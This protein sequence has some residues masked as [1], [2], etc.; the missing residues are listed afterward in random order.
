MLFTTTL[1]HTLNAGVFY[2]FGGR[3]NDGNGAG[4]DQMVGLSDVWA[5]TAS[6]NRWALLSQASQAGTQ[7]AP[8]NRQHAAM[9]HAA[10]KLL[11]FG[12]VDPRSQVRLISCCGYSYTPTQKHTRTHTHTRTHA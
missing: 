7:A 2:I 11:L 8:S 9:A 12:G 6:A 4:A 10:G 5:Y 3:T 1:Y